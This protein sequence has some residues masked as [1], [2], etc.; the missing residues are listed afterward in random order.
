M[1]KIVGINK[2]RIAIKAIL[3][4]PFMQNATTEVIKFAIQNDTKKIHRDWQS[5]KMY[6]HATK[7]AN[8]EDCNK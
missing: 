3:P 2:L 6:I 7:Q 4:F 1:K 8:P 5:K